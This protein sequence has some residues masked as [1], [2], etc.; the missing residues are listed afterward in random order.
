LQK[1]PAE[2]NCDLV[3]ISFDELCGISH[4]KRFEDA[5][6][7]RIKVVAGD[8]MKEYLLGKLSDT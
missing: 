5:L 1:Q 3:N 8:L 2:R 6:H 7:F 4:V